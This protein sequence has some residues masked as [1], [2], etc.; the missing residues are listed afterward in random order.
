[1]AIEGLDYPKAVERTTE[2]EVLGMDS[3]CQCP[4]CGKPLFARFTLVIDVSCPHCG[5]VFNPL[6]RGS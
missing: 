3:N 4:S 2:G 5:R 6:F 1:M